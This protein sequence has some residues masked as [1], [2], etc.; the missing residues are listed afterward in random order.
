MVGLLFTVLGMIGAF[1][2]LGSSGI[3][4]PQDLSR[5]IGFVLTSTFAGFLISA[6]IGFP[7][8]VAALII[9]FTTRGTTPVR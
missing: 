3:A 1:H 4:N 6:V 7:C 2:D 9:H 8:V 5:D